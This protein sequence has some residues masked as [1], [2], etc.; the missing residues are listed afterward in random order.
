MCCR[1]LA[2]YHTLGETKFKP[3]SSTTKGSLKTPTW[4]STSEIEA[5]D[6]ARYARKRGGEEGGRETT[7][8]KGREGETA[9]MRVGAY[10]GDFLK[11]H[12]GVGLGHDD[13]RKVGLGEVRLRRDNAAQIETRRGF[14]TF[15][16]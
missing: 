2:P 1:L 6:I 13:L 16:T 5:D 7:P 14:P 15:A 8:R 11:T 3:N 12:P 9:L 4:T 10:P